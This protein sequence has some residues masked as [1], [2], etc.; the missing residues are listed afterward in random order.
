M[1]K[2]AKC[3]A[4]CFDGASFCPACG[5]DLSAAAV[6]GASE[7]PYRGMV[8]AEKYLLLDRIGEGGMGVVYK[9]EQTIL[10]KSVAVKILHPHMVN[11]A[12]AVARFHAEAK[13][14]S[15]LNHPNSISVIDFGET[16]GGLFYLVTE[17]LRGEPLG[18][19]MDREKVL[20]LPAAFTIMCQVMAAMGEAHSL[21]I[22][23]RDLKP[24]N[25]FVEIL[26]NGTLVAKVL[27]FGIAKRLDAKTTGLTTPGMV[28][29]T[30]DYMAPEQARGQPVDKKADIYALGIVFYELVTGINPFQ[31]GSSAETMVAQVEH[32]PDPASTV[33]P[34]RKL[35]ETLDAILMWALA[36]NSA[37]RFDSM[38]HF[39]EVL[40]DWYKV[41][42]GPFPKAGEHGLQLARPRAA[43]SLEMAVL[44]QAVAT[45]GSEP[46][47]YEPEREPPDESIGI[48]GREAAAAPQAAEQ[49]GQD[50][51]LDPNLPPELA[52]MLD[53][54][55]DRVVFEEGPQS[56]WQ[57]ARGEGPDT[58]P[59]RAASDQAD[60]GAQRPGKP[61]ASGRNLVGRQEQFDLALS[62]L[63]SGMAVEVIGE[64]GSG[65]SALLESVAVCMQQQNWSVLRAPIDIVSLFRPLGPIRQLSMELLGLDVPEPGTAPDSGQ[66]FESMH[67]LGID[68]E[69]EYGLSEL[70]GVPHADERILGE[71]ARFRERSAVWLSVVRNTARRQKLL[72]IF[73]DIDHYDQ[74]SLNLLKELIDHFNGHRENT[75][76]GIL[77][78]RVDEGPSP[79]QAPVETVSLSGLTKQE[80][81]LL[82]AR[83]LRFLDAREHDT[84]PVQIAGGNPFYVEQ[85]V[86]AAVEGGIPPGLTR[87]LDL[88]DWRLERV[89]GVTRQIL[90]LAA[91]F[92]EPFTIPQITN[93]LL[94]IEQAGH[95]TSELKAI[96][97]D[98]TE[99]TTE[100]PRQ[101]R[102]AV[103]Q[104]CKELEKRGFLLEASMGSWK[105][106]HRLIQ[107]TIEAGMPAEVRHEYH[108]LVLGSFSQRFS[109]E[110]P[111]SEASWIAH[112]AEAASVG[113]ET[114]D[115]ERVAGAAAYRA[116][117]TKRA[118]RHWYKAVDH[119]RRYWAAGRL[120]DSALTAEMVMLVRLLATALLK[121]DQANAGAAMIRETLSLIS[122]G[123]AHLKALMLLDLGRLDLDLGRPDLALEELRKAFSEVERQPD[124]LW[125]TR[126][127]ISTELGRLLARRGDFEGSIEHLADGITAAEKRAGLGNHHRWRI[128]LLMAEV[129]SGWAKY[130]QARDFLNNALMIAQR[131]GSL[132]GRIESHLALARFLT[133]RAQPEEALGHLHEAVNALRKARNRSTAA[134][135]AKQLGMTYKRLTDT[136]HAREWFGKAARWAG[137]VGHTACR[138]A[139]ERELQGDTDSIVS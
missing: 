67:R 37:E 28:C 65:K 2:C 119:L 75:D 134:E 68:D 64:P 35:P 102:A 106:A 31:R 30:P 9:A 89:S 120:D 103:Q 15:R 130:D 14:A 34:D 87:R 59:A 127:E 125:W 114:G 94:A 123:Q 73:D 88:L 54:A 51:Q 121:D 97:A 86:R 137:S 115:V 107:Q 47:R 79:W 95:T 22:V 17:F 109:G 113:F 69:E 57:T 138:L 66:I 139:A 5:G 111:P 32:R 20:P 39:L 104:S 26:G 8:I 11:D 105:I 116:G 136:V 7:D 96:A 12:N 80:S 129:H 112:H 63:Q 110:I 16:E 42:V 27:D 13:A 84:P 100:K 44:E 135:V 108:Q 81:Q 41:S 72:L 98:E 76:L 101:L 23:H 33:A 99:K 1:K 53:S 45:E 46:E 40:E 78:G 92:S 82:A 48:S 70:L 10:G 77:V 126:A 131:S 49:G 24:D 52:D 50:F 71:E 132:E 124:D 91:V 58:A 83:W 29:G 55:G 117:D 62:A 60:I 133:R 90:Q 61:N 118:I 43:S 18:E 56:G 122:E 74:P 3:K 93:A 38:E 21:G 128:P 85:A 6:V 25:I 36:K 19:I 4:V